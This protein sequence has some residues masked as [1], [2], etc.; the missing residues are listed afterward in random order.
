MITVTLILIILSYLCS[1]V[2]A[3]VA[4]LTVVSRVKAG[5]PDLE[6]SGFLR[7]KSTEMDAREADG[8]EFMCF[9]LRRDLMGR[10]IKIVTILY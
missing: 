9:R 6:V 5:Y 2:Q 7:R 10:M 8:K 3:T 4:D 1:C